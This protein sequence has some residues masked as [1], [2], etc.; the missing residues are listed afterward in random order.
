MI[1][2]VASRRDELRDLCSRFGVRRLD[3][4]GSAARGDFDSAQ[5]DLDFLV[6]FEPG[7]P[8]ALTLAAYFDF[9]LA[10]EALFGRSVDLVEAGAIRNPHLRKSIGESQELVFEA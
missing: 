7:G 9:K 8:G 6:E 3:L 5:S 10:L 2:D 4:F 1:A